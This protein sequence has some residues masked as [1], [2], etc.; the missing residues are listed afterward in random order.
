MRRRLD[1]ELVRRG[2]A[3]TRSEARDA[4]VAGRVLVGGS[5]A[6][7]AGTL[8]A[9]EEA[10]SVSGEAR[11]YASRA[12]E[13]L[14]AALDRFGID[15]AGLA[16]LD[17]G[18]GSGGFTDVLLRRG[19][20][21]VTAVDVG[22]G[23]FAW[24][25]RTDPRVTLLERR[26]VRD[27]TPGDLP[28]PADLVVADL[29]FISLTKVLDALAGVMAP[30]AD[31]VLLVKPQ[32]EA[33]RE[34]VGSGGVVRDP[35]VWR[36]VLRSVAEDA[37]RRE[38]VPVGLMAS[39]VRGPAGNVEFPLHVRRGGETPALDVERAVAEGAA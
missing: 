36:R 13:K 34:D 23:Q 15:P 20:A 17:V 21:H 16:C 38:L 1:V 9:P 12:G 3:G 30:Q 28:D 2:L 24:K 32:F 10:V 33:G 29:S 11:P 25:L 18:A 35:D 8:I 4:I 14:A 5:V 6:R 19:A 37:R 26:N 31:G 7:K 22:Y 27:L 39:P